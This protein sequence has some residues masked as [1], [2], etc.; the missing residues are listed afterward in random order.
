MTTM[1]S[2][3]IYDIIKMR[4][5]LENFVSHVQIRVRRQWTNKQKAMKTKGGVER[6][7][8]HLQCYLACRQ[9]G[10][11]LWGISGV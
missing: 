6:G 1:M 2:C 3:K 9:Y 11:C 5:G 8:P 10:W 7:L 4:K